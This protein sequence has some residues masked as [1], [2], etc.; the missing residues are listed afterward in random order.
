MMMMI[1]D[2]SCSDVYVRYRKE[3]VINDG[4]CV[5]YRVV[6]CMWVRV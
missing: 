5:L 3:E 2:N 4:E 1:I 6:V